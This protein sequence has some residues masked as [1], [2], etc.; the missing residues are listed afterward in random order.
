MSVLIPLLLR[1]DGPECWKENA[2]DIAKNLTYPEKEVIIFDEAVPAYQSTYAAEANSRNA[3]VERFLKDEHSHVFWIDTDIVKYDHDIIEKLLALTT[4]H[5]IAPYVFIEDNP[6][7][8]FKR[9]YDINGFVDKDYNHFNFREPFINYGKGEVLQEVRS[10]GACYLVPACVYRKGY[11]Y[12]PFA[13]KEL[14]VE[15]LTL[16]EQLKG[17]YKVYATPLLEVSHAFLP[18]YGLDFHQ[19]GKPRR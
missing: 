15:H 6:S 3:V 18:F 8:N 11:R 10:V 13:T 9:F 1:P 17:E 2:T 16:F 19:E 14:G 12:D 7:W 4:E 5:I